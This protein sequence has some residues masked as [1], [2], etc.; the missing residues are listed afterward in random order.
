MLPGSGAHFISD[1]LVFLKL[2]S[3]CYLIKHP[4]CAARRSQACKRRKAT[5][6]PRQAA[7]SRAEIEGRSSNTHR[8]RHVEASESRRRASAA[9]Q[10][11][12]VREALVL[13]AMQ[14]RR[15]QQPR[16]GV[17]R[18]G[19]ARRDKKTGGGK[20]A[21]EGGLSSA[22]IRGWPRRGRAAAGGKPAPEA[23]RV[24][25]CPERSKSR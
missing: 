17:R 24:C 19:D 6:S 21:A 11:A 12:G 1:P 20:P 10:S 18:H 15:G 8:E 7:R 23:Q 13:A 5:Q 25:A 3:V 9:W 16:P 22:V 4:L 2:D 14:R